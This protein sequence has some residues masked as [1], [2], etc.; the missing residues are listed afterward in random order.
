MVIV[1]GTEGLLANCGGLDLDDNRLHSGPMLKGYPDGSPMHDVSCTIS[2]PAAYDFV[3]TF[4][5]RWL[6]HPNGAGIDGQKGPL[7]G[8]MTKIPAPTG[9]LVVQVGHTY[10]NGE[11]HL[12]IPA[13]TQLGGYKFAPR[14]RHTARDMILHAIDSARRFIYLEDQYMVTEE[15]RDH[16]LAA[17]P[18]IEHLTLLVTADDYVKGLFEI[19]PGLPFHRRTFLEPLLTSKYGNKVHAF[20]LNPDLGEHTYVHSKVWIFDDELA[21]IGSVNCN[22]RS[23]THDSEVTASIFDPSGT[24]ARSLRVTLWNE[25]LKVAPAQLADGVAGLQ[26]WLQPRQDARIK[27]YELSSSTYADSPAW[28]A[29]RDPDGNGSW[30]RGLPGLPAPAVVDL[31]STRDAVYA[32]SL[33]HVYRLDASSGDVL[34]HNSLPGRGN[35][36]IRLAADG[37]RVFAGLYGYAIGMDANSLGTA[38]QTSLPGSGYATV[39]TLTSGGSVYAATNGHVYRLE[40]SSGNVLQHNA[41]AGRGNAEVRL[42]AGA[43]KVFAG[44]NGWVVGLDAN[45]LGTN[46]QTSLPDCGYGVVSLFSSHAGLYAACNGHVYRLDPSNGSVIAHNALPG[47]GAYET[48]VAES[49]GRLFAGIYGYVVGLDTSGLQTLWECSLPDCGYGIVSVQGSPDTVWAGSNGHVYAL[50][51]TNGYVLRHNPL[52]MRGNSEVRLAVGADR[53]FAGIGGYVLGLGSMRVEESA[54]DLVAV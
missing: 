9:D 13:D 12:G 22:R 48:R 8:E 39:S 53:L 37:G 25:H 45:T 19:G 31:V 54:R 46:W 10:G 43:G 14:G 17:L 4:L 47:R 26:H 52:L 40:P 5:E 15:I 34:Q 36:E 1:Q 38:W 27:A 30:E 51:P 7:L 28:D 33:G 18:R 49:K 44:I 21:M 41:L 32:G 42:G 35:Y 2:G 20:V 11:M 6:D 23:L 50:D 3:Q 29:L 24:F 16:L